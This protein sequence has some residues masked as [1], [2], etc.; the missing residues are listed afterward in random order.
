MNAGARLPVIIL[1]GGLGKRLRS[2]TKD[3][4]PKPMAPIPLA[5][6][7]YPFLEFPLAH[8]RSQGFVEIV[9]CIGHLG[10]QICRHFGDGH[11]FDL[12]ISYD[13]T[14]LADTGH[15][16][17]HATRHM[18]AGEYLVL[19]GDVYHAFELSEF[20]ATFGRHPEWALQLAIAPSADNAPANLT[21]GNEGNISSY[22]TR[23]V[24]GKNAGIDAGTLALRYEAFGSKHVETGYSLTADLYP[25]LIAQ[26]T[27][28]G[29]V[30][31]K[32]FFDIGTPAGYKRFCDHASAGGA[33]PISLG[34]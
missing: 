3:R 7:H 31:D 17:W 1:A 14:G 10:D 19:C 26:Q 5:G 22:D 12:A 13:D 28:G 30:V 23:G 8:L 24:K 25:R 21:V 6:E 9:I 33:L 15:R 11:R 4:T 29:M 32:P 18:R 34:A 27:L 20:V 16:V 2:V